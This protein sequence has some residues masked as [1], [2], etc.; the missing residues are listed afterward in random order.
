M[1]TN[2]L[3]LQNIFIY[4]IIDFSTKEKLKMRKYCRFLPYNGYVPK[5][6]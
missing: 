5:F 3:F 1:K 4:I 2:L 6:L